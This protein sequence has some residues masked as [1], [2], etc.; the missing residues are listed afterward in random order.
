MHRR[1][2]LPLS[3]AVAGLW[4]LAGGVWAT[5][6]PT[7]SAAACAAAVERDT[8]AALVADPGLVEITTPVE[9]QGFSAAELAG[10]VA[11]T[12]PIAR[13]RA[14]KLDPTRPA[15]TSASYPPRPT[16]TTGAPA[17]RPSRTS[18]PPTT[19][20]PPAPSTSP[21]PGQTG[22]PSPEPSSSPPAATTPINAP[23]S[24]GAPV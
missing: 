3:L 13:P 1:L 18:A 4:A 16:R 5:I 14:A 21:P 11:G 12:T 22:T 2:V 23:P 20:A 8:R 24:T 7:P 6:P 10:I 19:A 15:P 17:P 9:C